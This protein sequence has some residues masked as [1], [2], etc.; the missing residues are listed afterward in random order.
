[1]SEQVRKILIESREPPDLINRVK[2]LGI[3]CEVIHF[4]IGD[5]IVGDI[6]IER[7][8]IDNLLTSRSSGQLWDQ[9]FNMKT[10]GQ[11]GILA[12]TGDFPYSLRNVENF[13]LAKANLFKQIAS[14]KII[15]YLSYGI[16]L[17]HLPTVND[18]TDLISNIWRRANC[19]SVAPTL[20]KFDDPIKIKASMLSAVPGIGGKAAEYLAKNYL[21]LQLL[22]ST[23]EQI[24]E[25][26]INERRIGKRAK[27]IREVFSS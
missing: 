21:L 18:F 15:C 22:N 9:L 26:K 12:V 2:N 1:M 23:E 14:L 5:Y 8:T 7:K 24:S 19:E 11:K 25:I 27:K 16:L 20:K 4:D 17:V 3:P 6:V 13:T 10:S